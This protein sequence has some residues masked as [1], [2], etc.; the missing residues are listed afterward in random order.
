[1]SIVSQHHATSDIDTDWNELFHSFY[2]S[3]YHPSQPVSQPTFAHLGTNTPAETAAFE[4]ETRI[5]LKEVN[6]NTDSVFWIKFVDSK[7]GQIVGGMC[8]RHE[9]TWPK[10]ETFVPS[11]FEEGTEMRRL[12]EG[13]YGELLRWRKMLMK[14][15][16]MYGEFAWVDLAYRN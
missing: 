5:L 1:M 7:S 4:E 6:A 12:S 15:E 8:Y 3:W 16:D 14:G 2:T 11:W 9:L 10:Q 13:F